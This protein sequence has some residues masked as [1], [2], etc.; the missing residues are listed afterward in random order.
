[1][2]KDD[3]ELFSLLSSLK[4]DFFFID[5]FFEGEAVKVKIKRPLWQSLSIL[6]FEFAYHS[7]V[8]HR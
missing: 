7:V 2:V 1:M 4:I 3:S 8:L 5:K 6:T